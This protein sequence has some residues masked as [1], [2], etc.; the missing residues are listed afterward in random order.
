MLN[1][2]F[3]SNSKKNYSGVQNCREIENK[4]NE[5]IVLVVIRTYP[6]RFS[7]AGLRIHR[8]LINI[9]KYY[10]HY[11]EV[12]TLQP[13]G[14][15]T[16]ELITHF[17]DGIKINL[18]S[19]RTSC[20]PKNYIVKFMEIL[21]LLFFFYKYLNKNPHFRIIH[22]V[23]GSWF[24]LA[25]IIVGKLL[26]RKIILEQTL[27]GADDPLTLTKKN[28]IHFLTIG[29]LKLFVLKKMVDKIICISPALEKANLEVGIDKEKIWTRPNS[30]SSEDFFPIQSRKE[31]LTLRRKLGLPIN[32]NIL[33]SVGRICERK[34]QIFLVKSLRWLDVQANVTLLLIGPLHKKDE[35]YYYKLI[36]LAQEYNDKNKKLIIIPKA[37][38]NIGEYM[39]ASDIFVFASK[40]EGFGNVLLE[41]LMSGLPVV[42]KYLP[43]ISELIIRNQYCGRIVRDEN[44]TEFAKAIKEVL[45]SII[46]ENELDYRIK[47]HQ[48]TNRHYN[49]EDYIK[50]YVQIYNTLLQM[51]E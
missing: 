24:G 33:L 30:V 47:L 11:A 4:Q 40:A 29:W 34:N 27:L 45:N 23:G 13:D 26:G 38:D 9:K 42:M 51:K 37:M 1:K 41:A 5:P 22:V 35:Y 16:R 10:R 19:V 7:G 20:K 6:P 39:R 50:G 21:D 44:P 25:S 3:F 36:N 2:I 48:E 17:L 28:K 15:K 18:V 46:K 32:D 49:Y 43:R 14:Q 8:L 31:K 12:V